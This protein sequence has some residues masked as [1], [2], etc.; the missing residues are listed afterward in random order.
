MILYK[1]YLLISKNNEYLKLKLENKDQG[2]LI[3]NYNLILI[4]MIKIKNN[5][6]IIF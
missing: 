6:Q 2:N 1:Y 3:L 4:F 5:N